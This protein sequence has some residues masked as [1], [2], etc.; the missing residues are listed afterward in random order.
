MDERIAFSRNRHA[1][2]MPQ[3]ERSWVQV[4][5]HAAKVDSRAISQLLRDVAQGFKMGELTP[6]AEPDLIEHLWEL[7]DTG[8]DQLLKAAAHLSTRTTKRSGKN[9]SRGCSLQLRFLNTRE[10]ASPAVP[11]IVLSR[12]HSIFQ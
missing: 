6:R 7:A 1:N 2:L 5:G 9:L 8:N 10:T 3:G 12:K 4:R 11:G